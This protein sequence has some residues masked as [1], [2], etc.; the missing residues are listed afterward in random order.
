MG[1]C[2]RELL[3]KEKNLHTRAVA[4]AGATKGGLFAAFCAS[5]DCVFFFFWRLSMEMGRPYT[6]PLSRWWRN[7]ERRIATQRNATH[8]SA[9]EGIGPG[10]AV[11]IR[12]LDVFWVEHCFFISSARRTARRQRVSKR[13]NGHDS[14]R[15]SEE[16]QSWS[17]SSTVRFSFGLAYFLKIAQQSSRGT[18]TVRSGV[19]ELALLYIYKIYIAYI[20]IYGIEYRYIYIYINGCKVRARLPPP[21]PLRGWG[22]ARL[23]LPFEC[24]QILFIYNKWN[25][26]YANI[27]LYTHINIYISK[28]MFPAASVRSCVCACVGACVCV[29]Q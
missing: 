14:R 1:F 15:S 23:Q 19:W 21:R 2:A 4:V 17:K 20:Y 3:P 9:S 12:L 8:L 27:S 22:A 10:T 11:G 5:A 6:C 25:K 29:L 7:A 18:H 28:Y 26:I 16:P 13:S 24:R